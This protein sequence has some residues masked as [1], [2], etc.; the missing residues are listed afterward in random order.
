MS[1]V[2][3]VT[4][5]FPSWRQGVFL[6]HRRQAYEIQAVGQ[7]IAGVKPAKSDQEYIHALER[8]GDLQAVPQR[9]ASIVREMH[10]NLMLD[11]RETITGARIAAVFAPTWSIIDGLTASRSG[12]RP[13]YPEVDLRVVNGGS[14][15]I[16]K[17]T[18][19]N[20]VRVRRKRL[21]R[22]AQDFPYCWLS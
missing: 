17:R 11:A 19:D 2:A 7:A 20:G 16:G 12:A 5:W 14:V 21:S 18:S 15:P 6:A 13:G 10:P 8:Y 1:S 3:T 9:I 22:C 4:D